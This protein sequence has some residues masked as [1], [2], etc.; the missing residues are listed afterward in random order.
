MIV[1]K[2]KDYWRDEEMRWNRRVDRNV[3]KRNVFFYYL[4][5]ANI[6]LLISVSILM[7]EVV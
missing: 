4:L 5:A 6:V 1:P 3:E 7:F 2:S